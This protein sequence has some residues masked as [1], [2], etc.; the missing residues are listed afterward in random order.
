MVT[1]S[2]ENNETQ[3]STKNT[4]KNPQN[5]RINYVQ[6]YELLIFSKFP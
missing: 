1:S 5:F 2:K 4:K 3:Q 6:A